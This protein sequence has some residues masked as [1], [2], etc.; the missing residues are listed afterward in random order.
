MITHD[1]FVYSMYGIASSFDL[2]NKNE[3]ARVLNFMP[4]AHLFGCATI[5]CVTYL[6]MIAIE[7]L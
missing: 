2:L 6:G 7:V 5:I 4:L 1:N 3:E